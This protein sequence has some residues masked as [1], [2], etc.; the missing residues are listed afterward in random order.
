M[1]PVRRFALRA[2]ATRIRVAPA[3]SHRIRSPARVSYS[4]PVL[5]ADSPVVVNPV[6]ARPM[7]DV[8]CLMPL[9]N[10]SGE[11]PASQTHGSVHMYG[12]G[13]SAHA[14]DVHIDRKSTRLN[15]SHLVISY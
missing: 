12:Y 15:S 8:V 13:T 2:D 1:P 7:D 9:A 14:P 5:A 3:L 10:H 4:G 11:K 6:G